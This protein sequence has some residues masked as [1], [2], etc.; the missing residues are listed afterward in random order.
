[1]RLALHTNSSWNVN[2]LDFWVHWVHFCFYW[3]K[4]QNR[5]FYFTKVFFYFFFTKV[6]IPLLKHRILL[7]ISEYLHWP[8]DADRQRGFSIQ[9]R[10]TTVQR[11]KWTREKKYFLPLQS[12][13]NIKDLSFFVLFLM[14]NGIHTEAAAC[15]RPPMDADCSFILVYL[16]KIWACAP[17][18]SSSVRFGRIRS[19]KVRWNALSGF[20]THLVCRSAPFKRFRSFLS[21]KLSSE[22]LDF[23]NS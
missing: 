5:Y 22:R 16:L 21:Y 17:A 9:S 4:K 20:E 15:W 3:R 18:K 19:S 13:K 7:A 10:N 6:L 14:K 2:A 8:V 23:P 11:A 1:M 12:S